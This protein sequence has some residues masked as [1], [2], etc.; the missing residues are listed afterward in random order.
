MRLPIKGSKTSEYQNE[1][2]FLIQ[3]EHTFD[4]PS[5]LHYDKAMSWTAG[6]NKQIRSLHIKVPTYHTDKM[7][8]TVLYS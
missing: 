3:D 6:G 1:Y 4:Y 7:K 2:S 8:D 5:S